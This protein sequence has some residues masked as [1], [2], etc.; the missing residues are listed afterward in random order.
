MS[1]KA[2]LREI[3][4][5]FYLRDLPSLTPRSCHF[6]VME[7]RATIL[8]GMR[9]CGKTYRCYQRMAELLASGIP[10][11]RLL[12]L[13]FEDERLNSFALAD[14]QSILDV[15]YEMYPDNRDQ[16]C[17]FFFDE[18]QN[19][20]D[21]AQFIRRIIDSERIQVSITGSSSKMLSE[22]LA[23]AM[24]GREIC[25]KVMPFSFEEFI[26]YH[27]YLESIPKYPCDAERSKIQNALNRYF[28]IGG[29]P[30][31]QKAD[32]MD[33]EPA[34]QGLC[35]TVVARDIK[36]RHKLNNSELVDAIV[37][38]LFSN[39]AEQTSLTK[40]TTYLQNLGIKADWERV[41]NCINYLCDAFLFYPVEIADE[42]LLRRKRNPIKYYATDIGLVRAMSLRPE[43][44]YGHLLENMVFLHLIRGDWRVSYVLSRTDNSE[45]DF[46]AYHPTTKQKRLVQ[47][48]YTMKDGDTLK[49]EIAAFDRAGKFLEV[50]DRIIVTWDEEE[51]LDSAIRVIPAW[52]FFL[53]LE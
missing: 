22:E 36:E 38:Y 3:V 2:V 12:Y 41:K 28:T 35:N 16:L 7:G 15:Y 42:S 29:F 9:R 51:E 19:V 48:S 37:Q 25:T 40:V 11:D 53:D 43:A 5:R 44:N 1:M 10:K 46:Y 26:R 20:P 24:R 13:N 31:I 49:R 30:E 8:L 17:Y 6:P 14:C 27:H 34:L 39:I 52:K 18:I 47:V 50:T 4:R 32:E 23:T 33:I 21:W 45:I